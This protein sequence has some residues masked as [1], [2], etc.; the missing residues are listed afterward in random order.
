MNKKK[1]KDND[2][3]KYLDLYHN[4]SFNLFIKNSNLVNAGYG[5]FTH[6]FIPKNSFIDY[7][8]GDIYESSLGG[9]Y[10]FHINDNYGIDA[11]NQPRCYMAM[12]NDAD[13]NLTL[14]KKKKKNKHISNVVSYRN[15]CEFRVNEN[16]LE[17]MV[18]SIEDIDNGSELFIS[19][20]SDYW[21]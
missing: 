2:P 20:G 13:F 7:Y 10:Y 17:V 3:L 11:F 16:E 21:K 4:S 14:N 1:K 5:V 12:L 19:Y 6:D 18:Y 8:T 15:N 9:T